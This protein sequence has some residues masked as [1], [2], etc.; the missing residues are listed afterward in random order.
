MFFRSNDYFK[1]LEKNNKQLKKENVKLKN[2]L[3][4][5]RE[6]K[7]EYENLISQVDKQK[8][9]YIELNEKLGNLISQCK[10]Q[11]YDLN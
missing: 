3:E 1:Y 4:S 6:Y 2:E 11:L 10:H 9:K 8:E 5:V 7:N